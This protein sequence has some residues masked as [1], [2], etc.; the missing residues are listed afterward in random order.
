MQYEKT[1]A[2][3]RNLL[4]EQAWN[5]TQHLGWQQCP[6]LE[7]T[8]G[9]H[10]AQSPHPR[11]ASCSWEFGLGL[12]EVASGLSVTHLDAHFSL[13]LFVFLRKCIPVHSKLFMCHRLCSSAVLPA[14]WHSEPGRSCSK[15]EGK[16][17][18]NPSASPILPESR[19]IFLLSF[20]SLDTWPLAWEAQTASD[21]LYIYSK[22]IKHKSN[23]VHVQY[24]L[25]QSSAWACSADDGDWALWWKIALDDPLMLFFFF[26]LESKISNFV[27]LTTK[28]KAQ[29]NKCSPWET[30]RIW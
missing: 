9:W 21:K 25:E 24:S 4:P 30:G 22:M 11:K 26:F 27:F 1:T 19:E 12:S 5:M 20:L 23:Q 16:I 15:E 18:A 28:Q 29:N 3:T 6:D 7:Q 2:E 14:F 13:Y 17:V 8:M 10:K